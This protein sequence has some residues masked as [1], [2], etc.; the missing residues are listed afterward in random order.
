MKY[1]CNQKRSE[2][3][4]TASRIS[5][6]KFVIDRMHFKGHIDPWCKEHCD[7]NRVIE[8]DKVVVYLCYLYVLI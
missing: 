8:M 7:P 5:K 1:A 3:T 6:M 4:L 2:L